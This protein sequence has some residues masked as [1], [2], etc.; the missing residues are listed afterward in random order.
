MWSIYNEAQRALVLDKMR[1]AG[2]KSVRLDVSWGMLQ[3]Y[4]ASS[5]DAWGTSFVDSVVGMANARGI[6]PLI[7]L[8]LTPAWANGGRGDR[9]L[10]TNSADY[11]RVAKWAAARWRGKVAGW[12]V[13][14]EQN[15]EAFLVGADPVAYT[16]L[17]RAAYPAFK[18]GDP[19]TPVVFGGLQY[20][21]TNWLTKSYDAGAQGYFDVMATHPY[22]GVAD[23]YPSAPDD[24]TMWRL[25]H[26]GAVHQLMIARG[27][28]NKPMWFTEFG[29]STHATAPGAP[30]WERGVS[31]ATQASYLTQTA[32]YVRQQMPYVTQ[33]YWYNERD[34]TTGGIQDGNYGLLHR[35]L[36]AKPAMTA[37]A[38]VNGVGASAVVNRYATA[39][40]PTS[41]QASVTSTG[42]R[43]G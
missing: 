21:D 5:Y 8:W 40:T 14:N 29:W 6:K 11:A 32:S 16:R 20:N 26:A 35:D 1:A 13:W 24:G 9:V 39:S 36:S 15:S 43:N 23:L 12:E 17:L 34:L 33:M 28:G 7:T 10:P 25:S 3:P 42:L 22:Q 19:Y 37:L 2:V 30:N 18:A 31:E 41:N 4:N 27:D 38:G